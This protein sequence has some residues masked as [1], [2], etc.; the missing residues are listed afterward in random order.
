[1]TL[2]EQLT[3]LLHAHEDYLRASFNANS[4]NTPHDHRMADEAEDKY[5]TQ[6]EAFDKRVEAL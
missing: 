3:A 4:C 2:Q 6:R 1:M 5:D